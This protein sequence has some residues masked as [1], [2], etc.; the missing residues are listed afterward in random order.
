[1]TSNATSF[2]VQAAHYAAA[3]PTYPDALFDWI[4]DAAP[5]HVTSSGTWARAAAR[6]RGRWPNGS[7]RVRATDIDAAQVAAAA[8]HDRV[9]YAVALETTSGLPNGAAD[10]VTVATA[11]HWFDLARFLGGGPPHHADRRGLFAAWTYHR[12]EARRPT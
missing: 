7:V 8:P 9:E 11:L 4:A 6:R 3:R 2:G 12:I 10:A 1:M 5:G